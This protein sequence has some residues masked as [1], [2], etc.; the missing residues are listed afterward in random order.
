MICDYCDTHSTVKGD[1]VVYLAHVAAFGICD[2]SVPIEREIGHCSQFYIPAAVIMV[3]QDIVLKA[4][5]AGEKGEASNSAAHQSAGAGDIIVG[6]FI[7]LQI[8]ATHHH[9][10]GIGIRIDWWARRLLSLRSA[11]RYQ[12]HC[13]KCRSH[14]E[15]FHE[16]P[17]L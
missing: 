14:R 16:S 15:S 4:F 2:P 3:R 7:A 9:S 11:S 10:E 12:K 5:A 1:R 6:P 17:F 8:S 13:R